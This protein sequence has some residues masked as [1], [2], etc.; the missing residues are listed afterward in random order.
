MSGCCA[1]SYMLQASYDRSM[2]WTC[3]LQ[4]ICQIILK[5]LGH[6]SGMLG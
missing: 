2:Y 4:H 1:M 6:C 3:N 5:L